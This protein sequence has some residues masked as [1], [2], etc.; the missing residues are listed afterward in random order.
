MALH[1]VHCRGETEQRDQLEVQAADDSTSKF[2]VL[3]VGR[4][5]QI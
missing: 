4:S 1:S 3:E 5:Y 2:V